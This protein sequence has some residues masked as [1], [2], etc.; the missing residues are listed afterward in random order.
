VELL[1]VEI[2]QLELVELLDELLLDWLDQ[3][4]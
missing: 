4:D 2:E 3:L 1:L